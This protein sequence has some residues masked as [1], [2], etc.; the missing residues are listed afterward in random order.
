MIDEAYEDE[1][2]V[3]LRA[4][5]TATDIMSSYAPGD[6]EVKARKR[7]EADIV[8]DADPH[9]QRS[10]T[11]IIKEAFGDHGVL[12]EETDQSPKNNQERWVIDPIDGTGNFHRGIEY[13]G[14]SIAFQHNEETKAAVV[15]SPRTGLNATYFATENGGAYKHRGEG[16][17]LEEA[18]PIHVT[19]TDTLSGSLIYARMTGITDEVEEQTRVAEHL[20]N[21]GAAFRYL[22]AGALELCKV[23]E[24]AGD[25][26]ISHTE[27]VWD[28]AAASLIVGEAGGLVSTSRSRV[29]GKHRVVA[30]NESLHEQVS[31]IAETYYPI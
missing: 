25:A 17:V 29:P 1:L 4:A 7:S 3:A 10:I 15:A 20:V 30:A 31:D 19:S 14:V 23:A 24:G 9:V 2:S 13:F 8:T 5:T 11:E 16:N 27:A 21:Q 6:A 18:K 22:G 12:A 26:F 28:Y